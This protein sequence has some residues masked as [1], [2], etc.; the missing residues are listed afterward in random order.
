MPVV[1]RKSRD[2]RENLRNIRR[3]SYKDCGIIFLRVLM[4]LSFRRFSPSLASEVKS[5]FGM[6]IIVSRIPRERNQYSGPFRT[7]FLEARSL[8]LPE[9][10]GIPDSKTIGMSGPAS[11][12]LL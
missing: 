3:T 4:I 8:Y 5:D 1:A 11:E 9:Y 7:G 10:R 2:A 6:S 12:V